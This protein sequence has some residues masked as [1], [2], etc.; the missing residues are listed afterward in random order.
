MDNIIRF[1]DFSKKKTLTDDDIK[2]LFLGLVNLIKTNAVDDVST[3]IKKEYKK[4]SIMLN[5]TLLELKIK[6][7]IIEELKRENENLK[8][9]T[10]SLIKK[11]EELK[12]RENFNK[13]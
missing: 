12:Q 5:N 7:E 3:K 11:I 6:N 13:F 2:S 9:K 10:N 1:E 4:N 8:S